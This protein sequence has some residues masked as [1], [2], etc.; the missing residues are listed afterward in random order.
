MGMSFMGCLVSPPT[1]HSSKRKYSNPISQ[2]LRRW[3]YSEEDFTEVNLKWGQRKALIQYIFKRD[4]WIQREVCSLERWNGDREKAA[5]WL[6][7]G[8]YKLRGWKDFWQAPEARR[9]TEGFS[10]GAIRG[11]V[12]LPTPQCQASSFQNCEATVSVVL[13]HARFWRSVTAA[14]ED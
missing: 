4:T 9:G 13:S 8:V 7:W 12:A 14:P 2:Y 3:P 11:R 1:P 10:P 5:V 6:E